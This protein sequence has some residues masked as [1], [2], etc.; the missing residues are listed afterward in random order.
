ML[1]GNKLTVRSSLFKYYIKN[2]VNTTYIYT[3]KR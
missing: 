1:T 2:R 3:V